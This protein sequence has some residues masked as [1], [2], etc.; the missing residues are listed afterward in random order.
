ME[1]SNR[2][3]ITPFTNRLVRPGFHNAP[4]IDEFKCFTY[5]VGSLTSEEGS[6][7]SF[8]LLNEEQKERINKIQIKVLKTLDK[9]KQS[10]EKKTIQSDGFNFTLHENFMKEQEML[11]KLADEKAT[12]SEQ[13]SL[14]ERLRELQS[15][16]KTLKQ[17]FTKVNLEK[18]HLIKQDRKLKTISEKIEVFKKKL[19]NPNKDEDANK[20]KVHCIPEYYSFKTF[21]KKI[22]NIKKEFENIKEFA[23]TLINP[24]DNKEL[25]EKINHFQI[26]LFRTL[27]QL[28]EKIKEIEG[29]QTS[30]IIFDLKKEKE[31]YIALKNLRKE[32]QEFKKD[33]FPKKAFFDIEEIEPYIGENDFCTQV[34]NRYINFWGKDNLLVGDIKKILCH[35]LVVEKDQLKHLFLLVQGQF[36]ENTYKLDLTK[37]NG[38]LRGGFNP[39]K[40]F[41]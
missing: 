28:N 22:E 30:Y 12:P 21:I 16:M 23:N 19:P 1:P 31:D 25:E 9:L 11:Q 40:T 7:K 24:T 27:D 17:K 41:I 15:K 37:H 18:R 33:L 14:S 34:R 36:L 35:E 8:Y 39:D 20:V 2:N 6:L 5:D 10:I 32:I 38:V 29:M 3:Q 26:N 4:V 13:V